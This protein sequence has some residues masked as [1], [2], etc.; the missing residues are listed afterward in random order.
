MVAGFAL[1][2]L[3]AFVQADR[4]YVADRLIPYGMVLATSIVIFSALWLAR[5]FQTRLAAVGLV[6]VWVVLT[7]YLAML[8]PGADQVIFKTWY[9]T[10]YL[11]ATAILGGMVCSLPPMGPTRSPLYERVPL[12]G[13]HY[14]TDLMKIENND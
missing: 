1:A 11:F 3:G 8:K 4:I 7:F 14:E 2:V 13:V 6:S 5:A 10:T 9:S 12:E